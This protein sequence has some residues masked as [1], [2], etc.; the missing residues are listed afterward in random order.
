MLDAYT[1]SNKDII[2][3]ISE[4]F[5]PFKINAETKIGKPLFEEF[6]G[7]GYP[8]IIFLDENKNELD[9]FYG[10]YPPDKFL[11]QLENV[12]SG[13]N[14]FPALLTKYKLGDQSSET[15]F[16]LANKYLDRGDNNIAKELYAQIL[17]HSDVS[18][19]IF[20]K[21]KLSLGIIGLDDN[22][23]ILEKYISNYPD[24]PHLYESINYL[25]QYFKNNNFVELELNYYNKY[26]D[27]F[28][29]DPWFLNQYAWRM[30]ELNKN[31][32]IALEKINISLDLISDD[33]IKKAMVLDT[34]AEIYWKLGNKNKSILI[35]NEAINIEPENEYYKHQKNKFL[36][37]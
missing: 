17:N 22:Y 37:K 18:Y 34:K 23:K 14:T 1:F 16:N 26:I 12:L 30:T 35:I 10:Y 7:T 8:L 9:R 4:H 15:I 33:D 25:L 5:I 36:E 6:Q 20:H 2:S 27:K 31:L 32:D 24:T 28:S 29:S 3:Y 13:E 19:Q 21:S 11:V